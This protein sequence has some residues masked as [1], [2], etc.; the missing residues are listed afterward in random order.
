MEIHL[1]TQAGL[2]AVCRLSPDCPLPAKKPP[3]FF[4][5]SYTEEECSVVCREDAADSL[6]AQHVERG[7]RMLRVAGTLDFALT[8]ILSRLTAPLAEAGVPVFALSTFD[9]DYLLL[10]D[11]EYDKALVAL[12]N[13]GFLLD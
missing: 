5:V 9:T 2:Y 6:G 8:G 7:W 13:A 10:A 12:R 1:R 3:G 4:S 11:R